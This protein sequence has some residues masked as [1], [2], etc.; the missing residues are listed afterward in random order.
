MDFLIEVRSI[1]KSKEVVFPAPIIEVFLLPILFVIPI[2]FRRR[3]NKNF[4]LKYF[5]LSVI[6]IL[7]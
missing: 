4:Y 7:I 2:P 3:E 1:V 6:P 5:Y